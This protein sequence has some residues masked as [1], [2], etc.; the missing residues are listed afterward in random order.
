[1]AVFT[2][3]TGERQRWETGRAYRQPPGDHLVQNHG[4]E[5]AHLVVVLLKAPEPGG[6]TVA[7]CPASGRSV[8][9]DRGRGVTVADTTIDLEAGKQI[10]VQHFVVEPSFNFFWHHHPPSVIVQLRGRLTAYL[11][12]TDT[13]VWE[14]GYA[15]H[16]TPGHHHGQQTVKNESDETAE[17]LAIF[18]NAPEWLPPPLFGRDVQPPYA[19]CPTRSLL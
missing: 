7:G 8:V 9:T 19:D 5:P 15:Y 14:P 11:N 3:C 13:E 6:Q 12:C 17:M 2:P 16:H 4:H 18:Y 1:V 10:I